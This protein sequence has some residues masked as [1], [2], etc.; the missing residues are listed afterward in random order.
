MESDADGHVPTGVVADALRDDTA[1]VAVNHCS[2]VTGATTDVPAIV[3]AAHGAR[4]LVLVDASQS[5]GALPI[6]VAAWGADF[7]ACAG[8]KSLF[9][10]PGIGVL[11][12]RPG[13]SR[14]NH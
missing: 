1:L 8:H 7:V 5:V 9:G 3:A 14:S 4:A 10:L 6:D 11:Y 12:V 13:I 2:N